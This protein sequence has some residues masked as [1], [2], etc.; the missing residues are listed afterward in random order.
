MAAEALRQSD[1]MTHPPAPLEAGQDIGYYGGRFSPQSSGNAWT[2]GRVVEAR[3]NP[4]HRKFSRLMPRPLIR[5]NLAA[6]SGPPGAVQA[7]AGHRAAKAQGTVLHFTAMA[8]SARSGRR[9]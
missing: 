7:P 1:M 3:A 6:P 4:R 2:G 8:A 5:K 9:A